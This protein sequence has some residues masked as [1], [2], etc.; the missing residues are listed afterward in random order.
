MINFLLGAPGG[1]K[2]Y[3]AVVFHIIPALSK[4]RKV[5]TNL[6]LNLDAFPPEQR[7]LIELRAPQGVVRPFSLPAHYGDPWRHSEGGYGALYVIDECHL[8]MPRGKTPLAVSEWYSL[9]RHEFADVLLISQSYGKV[10]KDICEL[11]Q[12]LY[13]VRKAVAFGS[14]GK[15][16][17]KVFDGLRGDLVNTSVRTYQSKYYKFYKSHTLSKDGGNE[18]SANDITPIWKRWPFV[19]APV[20]LILAGVLFFRNGVSPVDAMA[21]KAKGVTRTVTVL[22]GDKVAPEQASARMSTP[23]QENS[24]G[25]PRSV[26]IEESGSKKPHPLHGYALHVSGYLTNKSKGGMYL[27]QV[28][29][30]GQASFTITGDELARAGYKVAILADCVA[31]VTHVDG[32]DFY[33]LC[34]APKI[35]MAPGKSMPGLDKAK[36]GESSISKI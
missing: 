7:D 21:P 9:H 3:E 13:R 14:T 35:T 26:Q 20:L 8:S 17:R 28:S 27:F 15:Y 32:A 23:V 6:A 11:V 19:L 16:I 4:G 36:A 18:E 33:S 30:N 5:I 12:V 31:R 1:G 25:E 34:D 24:P 22:P 29:Q 10:D 2:S